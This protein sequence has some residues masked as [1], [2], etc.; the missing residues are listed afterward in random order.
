MD[1]ARKWRLLPGEAGECDIVGELSTGGQ[2]IPAFD[3]GLAPGV[4]RSFIKN[5]CY[6]LEVYDYLPEIV[7]SLK[8]KLTQTAFPNGRY[9]SFVSI[10]G[11]RHFIVTSLEQISP[12]LYGEMAQ[13]IY[14]KALKRTEKETYQAMEGLVHNLNTMHSRAGAQVPFSSINYG[15]DTSPEGRMVIRNVLLAEEAGLGNGE[16]PIFPIHIF[17]VRDGYSAKP[18]DPNYD[19]F[20]LACRVSAKRLFPN[21]SFM[22]AP[23]NAQYLKGDD[24]NHEVAYMG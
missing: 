18:E 21:F 1:T 24:P 9:D 10:I 23:F 22:D 6:I 5:L 3:Y 11:L 15:T 12:L 8:N 17:K 19:L 4:A 14:V 7:E 16:T 2:S 20:K 13:S